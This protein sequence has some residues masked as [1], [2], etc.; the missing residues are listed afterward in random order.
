MRFHLNNGSRSN[1]HGVNAV[2]HGIA[3]ACVRLRMLTTCL[4]F[5]GILQS[6]VYELSVYIHCQLYIFKSNILLERTV[7]VTALQRCPALSLCVSL[8]VH[9]VAMGRGGY[10]LLVVLLSVRY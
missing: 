4:K 2:C 3:L 10:L 6:F 9:L 5:V 8:C 1:P 7:R